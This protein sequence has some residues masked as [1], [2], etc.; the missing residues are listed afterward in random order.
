MCTDDKNV[1]TC[2]IKKTHTHRFMKKVI[3]SFF[4]A[5]KG[6]KITLKTKYSPVLMYDNVSSTKLNTSVS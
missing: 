1:L 4:N 5:N 3:R 6:C 2:D